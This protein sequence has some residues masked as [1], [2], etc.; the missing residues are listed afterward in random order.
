MASDIEK[1]KKLYSSLGYN[2][3]KIDTKIKELEGNKVDLIIEIDRGSKTKISSIKFIG[4]K[5]VRDKRLRDIIA[6][7]EDKFWKSII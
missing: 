7:E 6:S 1:I 2:F 4:D 5:K 3:S